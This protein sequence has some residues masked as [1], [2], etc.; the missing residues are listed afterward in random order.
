MHG[1]SSKLNTLFRMPQIFP[2]KALRL[3]L[4]VLFILVLL[5]PSNFFSF[6]LIFLDNSDR[7]STVVSGSQLIRNNLQSNRQNC[8]HLIYFRYHYYVMSNHSKDQLA[9][10]Q[11]L[12][13]FKT[14]NK[15][16]C[17]FLQQLVAHP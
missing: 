9:V 17:C 11:A 7:H 14:T 16:H 13:E 12:S 10:T 2:R 8:E 4:L 3:P 1:N 6:S 5:P 15:I